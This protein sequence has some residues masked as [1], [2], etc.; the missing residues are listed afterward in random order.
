MAIHVGVYNEAKEQ[1]E[2]MEEFLG[3]P[4]FLYFAEILSKIMD[5]A[6]EPEEGEAK[7]YRE[8]F[9]SYLNEEREE[10]ESF[11]AAY[12]DF[13][14]RAG[15]ALSAGRGAPEEPI[16]PAPE[17]FDPDARAFL[18]RLVISDEVVTPQLAGRL[19]YAVIWL[20][21]VLKRYILHFE[22]Q[23][24]SVVP[25]LQFASEQIQRIA[26]YCERALEESVSFKFSC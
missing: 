25:H 9:L 19:F 13:I 15:E 20:G 11:F 21:L 17:E 24:P 4:S 6:R 10:N 3:A 18:G 14:S 2:E 22:E 23:D 26:A 1:Y 12:C 7:D 16:A 5:S 8:A